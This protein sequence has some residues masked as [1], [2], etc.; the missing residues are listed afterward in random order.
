M[1]AD[2]R[3]HLPRS[4]GGSTTHFDCGVFC[5]CNDT[6]DCLGMLASGKCGGEFWCSKDKDACFCVAKP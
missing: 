5:K 4:T 1:P 3:D 2:M 6:N